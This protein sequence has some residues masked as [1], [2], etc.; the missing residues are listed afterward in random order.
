TEEVIK[1]LCRILGHPRTCPHGNPIPTRCGGIIEEKSEP[2]IDL[3]PN[4]R[5]TVVKITEED[6]D[7]L[8]RLRSLG[9]TVGKS[10]IVR[11]KILFDGSV[12]VKLDDVEH[13]LS[14]KVASAIWVKK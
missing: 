2:L 7:L 5:G 6:L 1:S 11:E 9:L 8:Q 14:G 4:E 3:E 10:V 13:S 12:V